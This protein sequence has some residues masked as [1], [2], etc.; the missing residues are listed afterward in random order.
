M[1]R[2]TRRIIAQTLQTHI[3]RLDV[4]RIVLEA[5]KG[6]V[7][8][9]MRHKE[10]LQLTFDVLDRLRKGARG[11]QSLVESREFGRHGFHQTQV[12][13]AD[14]RQTRAC[15][16]FFLLKLLFIDRPV[17]L[18]R[19][20]LYGCGRQIRTQFFK[21]LKTFGDR[22]NDCTLHLNGLQPVQM[23]CAVIAP[24]AKRF[25]S[26]E[27][28]RSDLTA[29]AVETA[30]MQGDWPINEQQFQQKKD[31]AR[32]RLTLI[33]GE[34]LRLMETVAAELTGLNKRLQAARAFP[35]AVKD[36]E[37]QLQGLFVPHFLLN[38]PFERLKHYPRYVKAI[39]VR[40]ERL[41]NDPA[42]DAGHTAEIQKLAVPLA[43]EMA[44]RKGSVDERL[45]NFRWMI[46]ELR[47]SLFAQ[48]LRTPMPVS[49]K[50]LTKQWEALRRL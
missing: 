25:E 44:A 28:L 40:L 50:R 8:Q 10:S 3:D 18:H 6:H 22:R 2:V 39:N 34:Y 33:G 47:V 26:F 41:R 31:E 38:M 21:T 13:T 29:A 4:T 32:S 49:V 14:E 37:S 7:Q 20:G 24:I 46:E 5:F 43:R 35:E 11:L 17:A 1:P 23:Q 15:L 12:L 19:S 27:E 42:R 9:E 16:V 45:E 48:E 36:I 30:A